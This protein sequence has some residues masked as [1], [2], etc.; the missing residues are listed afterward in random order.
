MF[1]PIYHPNKLTLNRCET[2]SVT[3]FS[4]SVIWHLLTQDTL[5]RC[6]KHHKLLFIVQKYDILRLLGILSNVWN[7]AG[8]YKAWL[9]HE[10]KHN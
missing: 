9:Y 8:E 10:Q 2:C 5:R 6:K 4:L 7:I 3:H 1:F